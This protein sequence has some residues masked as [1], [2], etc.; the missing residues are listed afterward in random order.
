M[1]F[2]QEI[3]ITPAIR[4]FIT[5]FSRGRRVE[6]GVMHLVLPCEIQSVIITRKVLM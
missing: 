1:F 2:L 5:H 6:S 4:L 3:Y